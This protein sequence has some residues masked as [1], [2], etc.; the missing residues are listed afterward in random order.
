[1][2]AEPAIMVTRTI[3]RMIEPATLRGDRPVTISLQIVLELR[4]S[5]TM[6][7]SPPRN[8]FAPQL[9]AD[10]NQKA[11]SQTYNAPVTIVLIVVPL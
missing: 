1:M 5:F 10:I 3:G 4:C 6:S 8:L 9:C 2:A 11:D 7:V